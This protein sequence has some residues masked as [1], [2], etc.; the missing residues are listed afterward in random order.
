MAPQELSLSGIQLPGREARHRDVSIV[1]L[2]DAAMVAGLAIA[3]AAMEP[4]A[5]FGI[6]LGGLLCYEIASFLH[7]A[8][9]P[10][11]VCIFAA[12]CAAPGMHLAIGP[13]RQLPDREL[14]QT[15]QARYGGVPEELTGDPEYLEIV[16]K[17]VRGDMEMLE[18]YRPRE[19]PPLPVPMVAIGGNRDQTVTMEALEGWKQRTSADFCL[20]MID[21]DHFLLR[22][23]PRDLMSAVMEHLRGFRLTTRTTDAP[24]I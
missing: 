19:H 20:Q 13:I 3:R 22:S 8:G 1:S 18:T 2:R 7:E 4:F 11:P 10:L 9:G 5:L 23:N 6:S 24:G 14:I 17:A 15:L 12:A 21:G 16:A